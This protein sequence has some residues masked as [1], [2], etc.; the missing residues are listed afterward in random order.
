[1][2]HY[3]GDRTE[4]HIRKPHALFNALSAILPDATQTL[5]LRSCVLPDQRGG[6][7]LRSWLAL[8]ND[9]QRAL[10]RRFTKWLLPLVHEAVRRHGVHMDARLLTVLKT[11]SLREDLRARTFLAICKSVVHAV[12]DEDRGAVLLKGAALA[13]T[14]YPDPKLRHSHDI[15]ILV[16]STDLLG[17]ASAL[18]TLRLSR[19]GHD[20]AG[21]VCLTHDSGLPVVLRRELFRVPFY[22]SIVTDA[23]ARAKHVVIAG[24]PARVLSPADALLHCCGHALHSQSRESHRWIVDAWFIVARWRD[25]DWEELMRIADHGRLTIPLAVLLTYLAYNLDAPIPL[26]ALDALV[27]RAAAAKPI[28]GELA[29]FGAR[30]TGRGAFRTLLKREG[31]IAGQLRILK[32]MLLPSKAYMRWVTQKSDSLLVTAQY[33]VR[34]MRYFLRHISQVFNRRTLRAKESEARMGSL[35]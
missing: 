10:T 12:S 27:V 11:A 20:P 5:L 19:I 17:V 32:W 25:L 22:N 9:A 23:C 28:D 26:S 15:E 7:A 29:L 4:K 18:S 35:R 2:Q 16:P 8:Q 33:F 3:N 13:Q 31:N 1:M 34:P 6:E 30:S 21:V 24:A 14:A